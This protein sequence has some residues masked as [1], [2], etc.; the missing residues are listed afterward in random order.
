LGA[1]ESR[2]LHAQ[3]CESVLTEGPIDAER[4]RRAA[5]AATREIRPAFGYRATVG[6]KKRVTEAEVERAILLAM[7]RAGAKVNG[8]AAG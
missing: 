7:E 4:V 3:E 1:L 5:R 2:P 8:H 6:Y